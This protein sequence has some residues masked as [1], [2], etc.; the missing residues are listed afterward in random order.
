M[1]TSRFGAGNFAKELQH[2][3]IDFESNKFFF[4]SIVQAV[5]MKMLGLHFSS[6]PVHMQYKCE[7]N[8]RLAKNVMKLDSGIG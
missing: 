8:Q 7:H 1:S 3:G 6:T 5:L 2:Q 4:K